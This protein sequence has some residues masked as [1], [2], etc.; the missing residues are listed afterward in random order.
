MKQINVRKKLL[1]RRIDEWIRIEIKDF[2]VLE[3]IQI[4]MNR[5][6]GARKPLFF[7]LTMINYYKIFM[8]L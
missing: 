4:K 7:I 6:S 3:P 8:Q 5:G 2:Q 1:R